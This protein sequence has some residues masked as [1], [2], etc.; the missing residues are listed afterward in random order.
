MLHVFSWA[1]EM[2]L[3]ILAFRQDGRVNYV[4]F[5][6][7][8]SFV[9]RDQIHSIL[10]IVFEQSFLAILWPSLQRRC[11][12]FWLSA[13]LQSPDTVADGLNHTGLC[14]PY[15]IFDRFHSSCLFPILIYSYLPVR[16]N[17]SIS[18]PRDARN[19]HLVHLNPTI[20]LIAAH[21]G[22]LTSGHAIS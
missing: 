11:P 18:H 15:M 5:S 9:A 10:G 16:L 13:T 3:P 4:H 8:S 21:P 17:V 6:S 19:T 22:I 2:P 20:R 7:R 1:D 14:Y 12:C